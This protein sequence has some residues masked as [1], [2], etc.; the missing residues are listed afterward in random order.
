MLDDLRN[1][2]ARTGNHWRSTSQ[3]FDHHQAKRFGPVNGKQQGNRVAKEFVFLRITDLTDEFDTLLIQERL[4]D[5]FEIFPIS[6]VHFGCNFQRHA[7]APRDF[8]RVVYS[9]LRAD[10]TQ[11]G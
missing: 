1:R 9:L 2:A 3:G 6:I 4:D 7:R 11:K 5:G 10:A 8:D